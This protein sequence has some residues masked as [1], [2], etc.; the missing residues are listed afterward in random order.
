MTLN[1]KTS[2]NGRAFIEAWEGLYL[3]AYDDGTGVWTIGYGHTTPAGLPRVYPGMLI[4]QAQADAILT[5]DL[6][7]VEAD[8]NHHVILNINQNQFDALVAFDFNTGG[9][10][11]SSLL[12]DINNGHTLNVQHDLSL[13]C[14]GGALQCWQDLFGA[15]TLSM[16]CS[17]PGNRNPEGNGKR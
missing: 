3:K 5:S 11:R 12:R 6:A 15:G 17:Q 7:S 14:M 2:P 8:V 10:D 1:Y 16:S 13:W 9:L 4:T